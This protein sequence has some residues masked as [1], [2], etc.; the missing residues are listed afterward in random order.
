MRGQRNQD[1]APTFLLV[2]A[3]RFICD[4]LPDEYPAPATHFTP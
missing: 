4:P 2:V 3:L 1:S